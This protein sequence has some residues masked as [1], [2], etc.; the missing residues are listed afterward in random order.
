M[1]RNDSA[2]WLQRPIV[3]A[4]PVQSK[5]IA[6]DW[7][8]GA[9]SG[10]ARSIAASLSSVRRCNTCQ[11]RRVAPVK[12]AARTLTH[13]EA[14][15]Y[16]RVGQKQRE[17]EPQTDRLTQSEQIARLTYYYPYYP[18]SYY[19]I[20]SLSLLLPII[21]FY[22]IIIITTSLVSYRFLNLRNNYRY[23]EAEEENGVY[24]LTLEC[25]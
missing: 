15:V 22:F 6:F 20:P 8:F 12:N 21:I 14:A 16:L 24:Q 23:H 25:Q 18:Y 1:W 4:A 3:R 7:S 13:T 11:K 9:G 5:H 19:F 2:S 10:R 17:K